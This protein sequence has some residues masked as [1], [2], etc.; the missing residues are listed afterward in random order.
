MENYL[1]E[2]ILAIYNI[3]L[4][5]TMTDPYKFLRQLNETGRLQMN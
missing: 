2:N 1:K 4:S 5:F 3:S